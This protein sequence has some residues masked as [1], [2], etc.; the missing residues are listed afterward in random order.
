VLTTRL[1]SGLHIAL[2]WSGGHAVVGEHDPPLFRGDQDA[3]VARH[4]LATPDEA[5]HQA[6]APGV[7]VSQALDLDV[8]DVC[9]G[10][11][12]LAPWRALAQAPF[13][14]LAKQPF[15]LEGQLHHPI[16]AQP[17]V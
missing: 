13:L 2:T 16:H 9:D 1:N 11:L 17:V 8:G 14:H 6:V 7:L 12:E 3:G 4:A 10:H 5:R 15:A